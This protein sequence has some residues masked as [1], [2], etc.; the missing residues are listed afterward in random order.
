MSH[1]ISQQMRSCI[2]ACLG[3]Y[4]DCLETEA[5]C[6]GMSGNHASPEHVGALGDCAVLA[7]RRQI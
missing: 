3:C 2:E 5:H 4:R 6:I 7:R 1:Q